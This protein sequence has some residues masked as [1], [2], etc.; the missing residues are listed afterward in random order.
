MTMGSVTMES[1]LALPRIRVLTTIQEVIV[2]KNRTTAGTQIIS[3]TVLIRGLLD[4]VERARRYPS[5][6]IAAKAAL[7]GSCMYGSREVHTRTKKGKTR[8][9][10]RYPLTK[11]TPTY[12]HL[13]RSATLGLYPLP[14][15]TE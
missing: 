14:E 2:L 4:S 1:T 10:N 12:L 6:L 5:R 7:E 9:K 8:F 15:I 3:R 11:A 13:P